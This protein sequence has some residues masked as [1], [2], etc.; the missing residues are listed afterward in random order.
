MKDEHL[1][2]GRGDQ[3]A[4]EVLNHLAQRGFSGHVVLEINS[5]KAQTRAQREIDLAESLAFAR[6]HLA[7]AADFVVDSVGVAKTG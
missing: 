7:R 1:V 5:R 2:P 3:R 6:T 4:A